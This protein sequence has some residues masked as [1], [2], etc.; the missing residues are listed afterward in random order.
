M[1]RID[2]LSA[3]S[4]GSIIAAYYVIEM[5][6]RLRRSAVDRNNSANVARERLKIFDSIAKCF[7]KALD[8]NLRSRVMLFGPFCHPWLFARSFLPR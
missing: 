3:V 5:E 4:G 6:K 8:K 2:T 7:C 1:Q